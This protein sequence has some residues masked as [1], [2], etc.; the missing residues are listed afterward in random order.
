MPLN[1]TRIPVA[2]SSN[3]PPNRNMSSTVTTH[4]QS[5]VVSLPGRPGEEDGEATERPAATVTREIEM[6][7]YTKLPEHRP[8]L[9]RDKPV[10]V[11]LPGQEQARLI[12]PAPDRSF[13]FI[14]RDDIQR[15]CAQAQAARRS[16]ARARGQVLAQVQAHARAREQERE[17]GR[18][19]GQ[20]QGQRQRRGTTT[21]QGPVRRYGGRRAPGPS[22]PGGAS[23]HG[24]SQSLPYYCTPTPSMTGPVAQNLPPVLPPTATQGLGVG[25]GSQNVL[26]HGP[27]PQQQQQ[28]QGEMSASF[29]TPA[30]PFPHIDQLYHRPQYTPTTHLNP[31][32]N[33]PVPP[34]QTVNGTVYYHSS[35][36]PLPPPQ[37]LSHPAPIPPQWWPHPTS[38]T[39]APLFHPLPPQQPP[40]SVP[41][42]LTYPFSAPLHHFPVI[43]PPPYPPPYPLLHALSTAPMILPPFPDHYDPYPR[44]LQHMTQW[45]GPQQ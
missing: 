10:R 27:G 43:P 9:R 41:L 25:Q 31:S 13:V 20:G 7:Q 28:Q 3:P 17:R 34:G 37:W 15:E 29:A 11:R 12:Y 22:R 39:T 6:K 38:T 35:P 32:P 16:Q 26:F 30:Y 14:P 4:R 1:H 5:I 8:A 18:E 44:E 33:H 42:T 2:R 45:S 40:A 24:R 36:P 19:Q 21:G 23:Y